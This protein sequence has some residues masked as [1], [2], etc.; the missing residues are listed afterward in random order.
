MLE[1]FDAIEGAAVAEGDFESPLLVWENVSLTQN[2]YPTLVSSMGFVEKGEMMAVLGSGAASGDVGAL[3][4]LLSGRPVR[5][6]VGGYYAVDGRTTRR[7]RLRDVCAFVSRGYEI[8]AHL[9]A[10]EAMFF[11]TRLRVAMDMDNFEVLERCKWAREEMGLDEVGEVF[12]GG[13]VDGCEGARFVRGLAPDQRRRLAVA[14]AIATKPRVL[15]LEDVTTGLDCASAMALLRRVAEAAE[16]ALQGMAVVSSLRKPRRGVF[17]LFESCCVLSAGHLLYFGQL[18]G[19]APWFRSLG[20]LSGDGDDDG[21]PSDL[22]LDL[23]A[24]DCDKDPRSFGTATLVYLTDVATAS[25][26][27]AK[28]CAAS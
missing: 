8:P 27:F 16:N 3:M 4:D 6:E 10:F 17:D 1:S 14:A 22:F 24:I 23:V 19:A 15:F 12:V 2:A 20:Y 26:A 9:T 18:D 7:E 25:R 5:G 28:T 21:P 11:L 13:R